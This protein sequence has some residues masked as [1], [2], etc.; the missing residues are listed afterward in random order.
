MK[1]INQIASIIFLLVVFNIS[2]KCEE[3]RFCR[4]FRFEINSIIMEINGINVVG[5]WSFKS[6]VSDL[7][8]TKFTGSVISG[9]GNK[10]KTLLIKFKGQIPYEP[11]KTV[12]G[13]VEWKI[14]NVPAKGNV[15]EHKKLIV[16]VILTISGTDVKSVWEYLPLES[17]D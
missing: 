17:G 10:S 14:V 2:A 7:K 3:F 15:L 6:N 8:I 9:A 4:E 12:N 1:I 16:P 5:E 13:C 11:T